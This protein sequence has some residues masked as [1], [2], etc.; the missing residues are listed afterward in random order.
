VAQAQELPRV[1]IRH[2]DEQLAACVKC[3]LG[4]E[5]GGGVVVFEG[6]EPAVGMLPEVLLVLLELLVPKWDPAREGRALGEG[7]IEVPEEE[8]DVDWS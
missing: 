1:S 7:F 4:L 3:A 8:D 5:G 2:D 6:Q